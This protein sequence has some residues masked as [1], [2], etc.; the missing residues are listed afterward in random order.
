M[1]SGLK[2]KVSIKK[3][4]IRIKIHI[5][6]KIS[7]FLD[8]LSFSSSQADVSICAQAYIIISTTTIATKALSQLI[9]LII[10]CTQDDKS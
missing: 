8:F 4:A 10:I 5:A 7:E 1:D 6:I 9:I 2:K 3:F